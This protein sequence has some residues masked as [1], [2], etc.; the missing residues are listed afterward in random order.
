MM[1]W[2]PKIQ[3]SGVDETKGS[4]YLKIAGHRPKSMIKISD[5]LILI[6][7]FGVNVMKMR[8]LVLFFSVWMFPGCATVQMLSPTTKIIGVPAGDT[9]LIVA[10]EFSR[11]GNVLPQG[12]Y[13]PVLQTANGYVIYHFPSPIKVKSLWMH[14]V[15]RGGLTVKQDDPYGKYFI[16]VQN[17]F[18]DPNIRIDIPQ[19][20]KFTIEPRK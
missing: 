18:G 9:V 15:C 12:K 20:V 1:R 3:K 17:C 19:E 14:D 13:Y 2:D 6:I 5:T 7:Y 11:D 4:E 16:S 8:H 10:E